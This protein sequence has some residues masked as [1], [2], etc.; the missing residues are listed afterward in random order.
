[1]VGLHIACGIAL[2]AANLVAGAWGGIAWLRREPTVGFWYALRVAQVTVVIQ[3]MLGLILVFTGREAVDLHYLYGALPLLVSFLAELTRAGAAAQE[4]G[5]LDFKGLPEERQRAVAMAIVRREMGIMAVACLVIL[6][7]ALR[8]A[9][10][11]P[12]L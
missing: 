4:L 8:A 9:G 6:F 7:L 3:A 12:F 2:I 11:T 1:V 5:E 10:T